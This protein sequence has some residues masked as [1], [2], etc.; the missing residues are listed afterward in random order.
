M[1]TSL[2]RLGERKRLGRALYQCLEKL[3]R[4]R[5]G[6]IDR[7][8][9]A[10]CSEAAEELKS[11][12]TRSVD[13]SQSALLPLS[14]Q[15][16][17]T[18]AEWLNEFIGAGSA[19]VGS[20]IEV[21]ERSKPDPGVRELLRNGVRFSAVAFQF[22]AE[23]TRRV[24]LSRLPEEKIRQFRDRLL[25]ATL[26]GNQLSANTN[27]L[28]H[29][30]VTEY[31]Q[32]IQQRGPAPVSA[33]AGRALKTGEGTPSSELFEV[34]MVSPVLDSLNAG[35]ASG[36]SVGSDQ[37]QL[38]AW[39]AQGRELEKLR[40]SLQ[41]LSSS[42]ST[43]VQTA[44]E[45]QRQTTGERRLWHSTRFAPLAG[46]QLLNF[47][48]FLDR[49]LRE[50][51]YYAGVY[52][53][54]HELAAGA[55]ANASTYF[56]VPQPRW[57]L[58]DPEQLDFEAVDTQRCIGA[59][60]QWVTRLL[61]LEESTKAKQVLGALASS[62]LAVALG[63]ERSA[64]RLLTEPEW[65]WVRDYSLVLSGDSLQAVL[66]AMLSERVPCTQGATQALCIAE[67][68][69]A[70]FLAA[71]RER[72]YRPEEA[73]MQMALDEPDRWLNSTLKKAADR[74]AT[75]ELNR[76]SPPS[77]IQQT[78]LQ[79]LG[80][81]ELWTRRALKK[82][83]SPRLVIDPSS[84]PDEAKPPGQ[85]WIAHAFHLLPYRVSLD[86]SRGGVAL[87]WLEPEALLAD[88]LSI[89]SLVEPI[90][91]ES[92]ANRLSSTLGI[93]PTV[94]FAEISLGVG[95]RFSIHW[96]PDF[97]DDFG[98]QTQLSFLQDRFSLGMG[99]RQ[100]TGAHFS[101]HWFVFL[102]VSDFNGTIYWLGPWSAGQKK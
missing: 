24:A 75:I 58:E 30:V 16:V 96:T 18:L 85:V 43:F 77:S 73:N 19:S 95:P 101:Q 99:V 25:E 63:D 34:A 6:Q 93:L 102:S 21:S 76:S 61:Q 52:D 83:G 55:C 86:V 57:Q 90:D 28:A 40:S 20:M 56:D 79:A 74:S 78:F 97:G 53:G 22:L 27:R 9:L 35:I 67:L 15:E 71:L 10:R 88:W 42:I 87:A 23:E 54:V 11:G 1:P 84:L 98:L 36:S 91:Y 39:L 3:H 4:V 29:G 80:A 14:D 5:R 47:A 51:D 17:A 7:P 68:E 100:L 37:D 44:R 81:G 65:A 70:E 26:L 32:R 13:G 59:I 49:P 2:P 72:G 82:S 48:A 62:E 31:L 64:Q 45:L 66:G 60:M 41:Q 94:H 89:V 46:S 8:L 12:R 69:F 38:V 50:F 92:Q 33:A